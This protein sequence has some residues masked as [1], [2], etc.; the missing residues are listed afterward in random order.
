VNK[1]VFLALLLIGSHPLAA[2]ERILQI[3]HTNDLHSY[4]SHGWE[5]KVGGLARIKTIMDRFEAEGDSKGWVTIRLDAGDFSEG[6]INFFADGGRSTFRI[7]KALDYDAIAVGN[8]D[9]LTG[10]E[11]LSARQFDP[12]QKLPLISANLKSPLGWNPE[13][14]MVFHK[15]GM[16]IAIGGA[17]TNEPYFSWI[18]KPATIS[19]PGGP[20]N[21]FFKGHQNADIRIALTHLGY[22]RDI[23]LALEVPEIDLIVGGHTHTLLSKVSY[24]PSLARKMIPI[25][26][27]GAHGE[28]VGRLIVN[29]DTP[30]KPRVLNYYLEKVVNE[31]PEDP[32]VKALIDAGL[33]ELQKQFPRK[34]DSVVAQ[35]SRNYG[36]HQVKAPIIGNI[37]ADSLREKAGADIAIDT[38]KLYNGLIEEGPVTYHDVLNLAPHLYTWK[39]HGWNIFTC[40]ATARN[41]LTMLNIT[42]T[43]SPSVLISGMTAKIDPLSGLVSGI[44]ING[45]KPDFKR[46][47][48]VAFSEGLIRG[49]LAQSWTKIF[50][51]SPMYDSGFLLREALFEK[52]FSIGFIGPQSLGTPRLLGTGTDY[53]H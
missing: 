13:P 1:L 32:H 20:L 40:N 19:N 2:H 37:I 46:T 51:C 26:Q 33:G 12:Q 28:M 27:T 42:K 43:L 3:I 25:V 16:K 36:L 35:A 10:I 31:I 50:M 30:R 24:A 23:V 6:N 9:F 49:V 52:I 34:L 7:M 44:S 39:S 18:A 11:D 47:Y 53:R 8:H 15:N 22:A 4:W 45:Q 41:I 17:T 21:R 38:G 5:K 48:K 29:L 14:G